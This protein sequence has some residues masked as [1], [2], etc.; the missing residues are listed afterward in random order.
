MAME[1]I[2]PRTAGF[3]L[4]L[5]GTAAALKHAR[6]CRTRQALHKVSTDI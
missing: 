3:E 4:W 2:E 1:A 6:R 5:S